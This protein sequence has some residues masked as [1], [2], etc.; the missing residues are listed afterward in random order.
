MQRHSDFEMAFIQASNQS[1][2]QNETEK[3]REFTA[4]NILPPF[5]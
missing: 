5:W 3:L 2:Q 1:F 4:I